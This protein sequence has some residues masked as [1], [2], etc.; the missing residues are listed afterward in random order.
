MRTIVTHNSSFHTDDIF[1]V[2]TLGLAFPDETFKIVRSREVDDIS[3]ADFVIDVGGLY[4]PKKLRFDHHQTGGAGK[5][6]NG[7]PYASFGLVW[8][9]FGE[10][11]CQNKAVA[12]VI[13]LN[14]AQA[15]DAS[16]NG[17]NIIKPIYEGVYPYSISQFLMSYKSVEEQSEEEL[18]KTF[19]DL[20][21]VAKSLLNREIKNEKI[22]EQLRNEIRAACDSNTGEKI[23]V[24]ENRIERHI[25]R[26]ILVEYKEPLFVVYPNLSGGWKAEAVPVSAESTESR[27]RF[28]LSWAGKA[29]EELVKITGVTD[30]VFSH[31]SGFLTVVKSREG[32]MKIAEIALNLK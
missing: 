21:A 22:F 5:H 17:V 30:V 31:N 7:I 27:K 9:E 2:A 6:E 18:Y 20:V 11:I 32:A 24:L 19:I 8:K 16:D 1:A 14:L 3:K 10:S 28:P 25:W 4:E 15:I 26:P 13:D 12:K 23:I 29:G